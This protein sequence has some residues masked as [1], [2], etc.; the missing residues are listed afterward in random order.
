M[1]KASGSEAT[2]SADLPI[3]LLRLVEEYER[4]KAKAAVATA[5]VTETIALLTIPVF[6]DGKMR[7]LS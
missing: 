6:I 4:K 5:A 2:S 1:G 7:R 3:T